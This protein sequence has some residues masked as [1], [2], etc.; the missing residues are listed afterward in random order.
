MYQQGHYPQASAA[1]TPA[2]MNNTANHHPQYSQPYQMPQQMNQGQINAP[3]QMSQ[4]QMNQPPHQ[5]MNQP[6]PQQM[7]QPVQ[8]QQMMPPNQYYA[9]ANSYEPTA[10][11]PTPPV[12][13]PQPRQ[14]PTQNI[15]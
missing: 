5:Q 7:N 12:T 6:P 2:M 11:P 8:N 3:R 1:S 4:V 13:D 15:L 10:P 14:L 9:N